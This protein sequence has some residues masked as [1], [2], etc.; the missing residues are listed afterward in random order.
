MVSRYKAL[1]SD[2]SLRCSALPTDCPHNFF[3]TKRKIDSLKRGVKSKG[4]IF[5][6]QQNASATEVILQVFWF[7]WISMNALTKIFLPVYLTINYRAVYRTFEFAALLVG[8]IRIT[9]RKISK[10]NAWGCFIFLTENHQPSHQICK[11][12]TEYQLKLKPS[13]WPRKLLWGKVNKPTNPNKH[14]GNPPPTPQ[15]KKKTKPHTK[16][17]LS[18]LSIAA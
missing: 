16:S 5:S 10:S 11:D 1:G 8:K 15:E 2:T 6:L 12:K 18:S 3:T 14:T 13:S 7:Q 4:S 9:Q 17:T